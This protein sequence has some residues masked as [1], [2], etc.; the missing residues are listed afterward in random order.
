M[1]PFAKA[2]KE[3]VAG[4]NTGAVVGAAAPKYKWPDCEPID[5]SSPYWEFNNNLNVNGT[6]YMKSEVSPGRWQWVKDEKSNRRMA[7][8]ESK[9][10]NLYW[11]LQTRALSE[12]EEIKALGYG[13]GLN[14]DLNVPYRESDKRRELQDAW[15]QQRRLQL[16]AR[17]EAAS[18]AIGRA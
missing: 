18:E 7:E 6:A 15:F 1:W 12:E 17:T 3:A 10:R 2:I 13:S 9:R 5:K 16:L 4:R 14:I 11:A 8:M